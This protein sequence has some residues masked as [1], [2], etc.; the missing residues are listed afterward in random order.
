MAAYYPPFSANP[1]FIQGSYGNRGNLEL[2]A[3]NAYGG[4]VHIWRNNDYVHYP[5]INPTIFG[6]E[7]GKVSGVSLIEGNFGTP[8]NLELVITAG[9]NLLH[10]YRQSNDRAWYGPNKI[11]PET[12]AIG[13][14]SLIQGTWAT[15]GN[16]E[17][18]TP[19]ASGGLAH[20][21]RENDG[22]PSFPW[23]PRIKFAQSLG[24]VSSVSL[25]QS[26]YG[27]HLEVVAIAK[28]KLYFTWRDDSLRWADPIPIEAEYNVTG[29]PALIQSTSGKQGNFEL[30]VP[31]ASGGLYHF[32]RD[33][34]DGTKPSS[35]SNATFFAPEKGIF[36]KVGLIQ[37][38]FG[39][40]L[41]VMAEK[42]GLLYQYV[43]I[44]G[45]WL[46]TNPVVFSQG[47]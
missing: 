34:K 5:W 32:S 3:G 45:N 20:F 36:R 16:F 9:E 41:E 38:N 11:S 22:S 18:V 10:Y 26:N 13:V 6:A 33:N 2:V 12:K 8:G 42:D 39:G 17:L 21:A 25:I 30:V 44:D 4:V 31:A 29:N 28:E 23:G 14:P 35:W 15:K 27:R 43:R 46:E 47:I 37:S 1:S 19:L 24:S 7:V 40:N